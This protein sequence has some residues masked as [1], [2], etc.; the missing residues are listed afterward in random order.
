M[1][2]S[3]SEEDAKIRREY[4][5]KMQN[6]NLPI[7]DIGNKNG[8]TE[9]LD[10]IKPDDIGTNNIMKG[11]DCQMRPFFVF[12]A[13][14]EFPNGLKKKTFTTFFQRYYDN[15]LLWHCCGH[16]GDT[17][18]Y[19]DGG[20]NNDQIKLLWELFL[21]GEYKI[22]REI[23]HDQRLNFTINDNS[24]WD[25]LTDDDFPTYIRLGNTI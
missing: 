10:F 9:Y 8:S 19:T 20:T 25:D 16:Y 21:F 1:G 2:N 13:E 23:I 18:M 24:L 5:D 4:L 3:L 7:L 15:Q 17:L 14:F 22:N 11:W 12:R 6:L